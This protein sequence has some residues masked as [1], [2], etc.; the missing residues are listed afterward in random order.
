MQFFH[1]KTFFLLFISFFALLGCRKMGPRMPEFTFE[2][3]ENVAF[4]KKDLDKKRNAIFVFFHPTCHHCENEAQSL[5]PVMPKF[6]NT[7]IYFISKA[8]WA[9]IANFDSTFELSKN[10]I[11]VLRDAKGD[12][13]TQF[14]VKDIPNIFVYDTYQEL[15]VE[16]MNEVKPENLL[17][18]VGEKE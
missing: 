17:K 14:K 2:K 1:K 16:Y 9:E 6:N 7:D 5:V 18:D 10:G 15:V 3:A 8:E 12:G 13:K 11:H 4:L